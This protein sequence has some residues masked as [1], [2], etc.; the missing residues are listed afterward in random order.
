MSK[1]FSVDYVSKLARL[2]LTD[3]ERTSFE[4]QMAQILGYF[5][6]LAKVN[7]DGVEPLIHPFPLENVWTA[8]ESTACFTPEEAMA[9]APAKRQ[10]QIVVPKVVDDA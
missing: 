5:D 8:D 6:T 1:N 4:S 10:N 3:E 9:N 2:D 7:V